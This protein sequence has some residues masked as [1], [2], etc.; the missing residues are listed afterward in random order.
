[1]FPHEVLKYYDSYYFFHKRTGMSAS[2]LCN[3]VK[4]GY[5]PYESQKNI[6]RLSNGELK[7]QWEHSKRD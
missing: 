6:E 2:S 4:W 3:W 7:A 1:M 5:V